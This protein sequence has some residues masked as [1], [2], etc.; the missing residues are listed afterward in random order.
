VIVGKGLGILTVYLKDLVLLQGVFLK[1]QL[2]QPLNEQLV[3]AEKL[4]GLVLAAAKDFL[5]LS[6]A[7]AGLFVGRL[8]GE[9]SKILYS[10]A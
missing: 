10:V 3:L 1:Q 2:G 8:Y 4:H 7:K 9:D 5:D 6:L